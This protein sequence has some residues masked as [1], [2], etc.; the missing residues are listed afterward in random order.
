MEVRKIMTKNPACCTPGSTLA[1]VAHM[2]EMYD[3]GCIPVVEDHKTNRP[4]GTITDRDIAIRGLANGGAAGEMKASDIMTSD[5]ATVTPETTVEQCRDQMEERQIRRILVVD[6]S[7]RC[8]GIVAQADV[9]QNETNPQQTAEF[10][11]DLSSEGSRSQSQYG[12]ASAN[13]NQFGVRDRE[14]SG[15]SYGNY[16]GASSDRDNFRNVSN[17]RE[18]YR[19]F[20]DRN[21]SGNRGFEMRGYERDFDT[22]DYRE[23]QTH[24]K[25]NKK[26][27]KVVRKE[28][29]FF[30]LSSMLPL[31][32]S[33]GA[34]AALKYYMGVD[35][36]SETTFVPRAEVETTPKVSIELPTTETTTATKT[37]TNIEMRDG[38]DLATETTRTATSFDAGT[39]RT[40][41]SFDDDSDINLEIGKTAK[42]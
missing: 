32:L 5:V 12:G 8:V 1:E 14:M 35:K 9:V 41:T 38:R 34:G 37:Q 36:K 3:C 6:K 23:R 27:K 40:A 10:I 13:Y 26:F 31:L 28:K 20:S 29:G 2:M 25:P 39:T 42:L 18:T 30:S 17:D 19:G 16:G 7:G 22:E 33:I 21:T 15:S 4:V 24:S 11:R